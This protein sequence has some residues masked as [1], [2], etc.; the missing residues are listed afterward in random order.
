[1]EPWSSASYHAPTCSAPRQ[2]SSSSSASPPLRVRQPASRRPRQP[3][4]EQADGA[5]HHRPTRPRRRQPPSNPVRTRPVRRHARGL[6]PVQLEPPATTGSTCCAPTTRAPTPSASSRRRSSSTRPGRGRGPSLRPARR[7]AVRPGHGD[8]A[9][10]PG[11]RAAARRVSQHLA[12]LRHLRL[13]GRPRG[14]RSISASSRRCSATRPTTPRTTTSSRAPT[15]S[16]S[17]RSITRACA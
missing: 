17:C 4:Q 15:C 11:Q 1:M 14:C 13:P 5:E 2:R 7:P 12:G 6:L 16:T 9:G 10:Q 3:G 8:G